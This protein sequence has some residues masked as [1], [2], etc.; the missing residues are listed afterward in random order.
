[1]NSGSRENCSN[2]HGTSLFCPLHPCCSTALLHHEKYHKMFSIENE[3][4]KTLVSSR[5]THYWV[6]TM[7]ETDSRKK[8]C[9]KISL[10]AGL[11][12]VMDTNSNSGVFRCVC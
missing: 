1:M 10:F 4:D 12:S 2:L 9:Q 7:K 11:D 6:N 8:K 5:R 3:H